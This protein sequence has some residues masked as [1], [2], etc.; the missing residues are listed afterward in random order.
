MKA[1]LRSGTKSASANCYGR[2]VR[3]RKP[4][5][6]AQGASDS[7]IRALRDANLV[8][9]KEEA[10]VIET[11]PRT[12]V[13]QAAMESMPMQ[14]G[15]NVHVFNVAFG[16]PVNLS[17]W[18]GLDYEIAFY[19]YRFA[20][21]DHIQAAFVDQ[22]GTRTEV[23]RVIPLLGTSETEAFSQNW[24]PSNAVRSWR[25]TPYDATGDMRDQ[26]FNFGDTIS[27]SSR[28]VGRP[29]RIDWDNPVF[30][31]GQPYTM[32]PVY[33]SGGVS[34]YYMVEPA[35]PAPRSRSFR[36]SGKAQLGEYRASAFNP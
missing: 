32:Y 1:K 26:R 7:L 3:N 13:P 22:V 27:V 19:S 33:G 28:A 23:S 10:A 15:P 14:H 24:F 11:A 5:L 8:V 34:L 31:N 29:T 2:S 4:Y 9:T 30:I 17:Q 35:T 25:F 12:Q 36:T 16:H 20:G 6:K 18:G 21:E